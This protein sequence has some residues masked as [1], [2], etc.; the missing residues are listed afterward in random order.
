VTHRTFASE[1]Q[2]MRKLIGPGLLA[3]LISFPFLLFVPLLKTK[4]WLLSYNEIMLARLMYD[5]ARIDLFLFV[6]VAVFGVIIPAVKIAIAVLAWYW[7]DTGAARATFNHMRMLS[8][9]SMLD[10]MLLS[11]FIV[12]F[13]G[14]GFGAVEM[15]YGLYL[16]AV[17]VLGAF[18]TFIIL[19][20]SLGE[21]ADHERQPRKAA[22]R[23]G[24]TSCPAAD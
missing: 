15:R 19:E 18:A 23:D 14:L 24:R 9:L 16:Y 2:G 3:L 5:L 8:K 4:L 12:A 17:F 22:G 6:V 1:A 13:K 11:V 20:Q 10:L 21:D 7:L